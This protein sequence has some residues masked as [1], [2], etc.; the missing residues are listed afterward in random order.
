M[1]WF[2]MEQWFGLSGTLNMEQTKLDAAALTRLIGLFKRRISAPVNNAVSFFAR[3]RENVTFTTAEL[4]TAGWDVQQLKKAGWIHHDGLRKRWEPWGEVS[5]CLYS[6]PPALDGLFT[7]ITRPMGAFLDAKKHNPII[8]VIGAL[9][10]GKMSKSNVGIIRREIPFGPSAYRLD[11]K[12]FKKFL[13]SLD[14]WVRAMEAWRIE[15]ITPPFTNQKCLAEACEAARVAFS[16]KYGNAA[17]ALWFYVPQFN[18]GGSVPFFNPIYFPRKTKDATLFWR[19]V[20][21]VRRLYM[22]PPPGNSQGKIPSYSIQKHVEIAKL[23]LQGNSDVKISKQFNFDGE[24]SEH[25]RAIKRIT[26][27]RRNMGLRRN[28]HKK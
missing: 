26:R 3:R 18:S 24:D 11:R 1:E 15:T 6:E 5:S 27:A 14:S 22:V 10:G 13:D 7:E 19:M 28:H 9:D 20:D 12:E 8:E 23:V 2:I 25:A 17:R 4:K 21:L 16:K